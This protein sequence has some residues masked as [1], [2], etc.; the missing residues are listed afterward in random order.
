MVFYASGGGCDVSR[1]ARNLLCGTDGMTILVSINFE[2][3]WKIPI[4]SWFFRSITFEVRLFV[5]QKKSEIFTVS[6]IAFS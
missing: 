1:I 3:F 6:K 4:F 2:G 5:Y